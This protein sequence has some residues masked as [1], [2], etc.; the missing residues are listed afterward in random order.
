MIKNE[1]KLYSGRIKNWTKLKPEKLWYI[2][3]KVFPSEEEAAA[4][5]IFACNRLIKKSKSRSTKTDFYSFKNLFLK[6]IGSR[7]DVFVAGYKVRDEYTICR[8][9]NGTGK[10]Y[11]DEYDDYEY[12]DDEFGESEREYED[13]YEDYGKE[14]DRL[15]EKEEKV[16]CPDCEGTGLY[17]TGT[18]YL[19]KLN[20]KGQPYSFHSYV[21]PK[22]LEKEKGKDQEVFGGQ[23]TEKEKQALNLPMSGLF[24]ILKYYATTR[25]SWCW[26]DPPY[27]YR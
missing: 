5:A 6:N 12:E 15:R 26:Y 2:F 24:K 4:A 22:K 14:K 17:H 21:Q 20:V 7:K 3:L 13:E 9:C 11:E 19:W 18:L 8:R 10:C 16:T 27:L 1:K 23:F 25:W